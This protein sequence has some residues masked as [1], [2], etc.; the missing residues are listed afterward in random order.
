[1]N[2]WEGC[3][4]DPSRIEL[5]VKCGNE[6]SLRELFEQFYGKTFASVMALLRNHQRAEDITQEAFI[7]AFKRLNSLREPAKFG[8]WLASIATN[9]ARDS[10]KREKKYVLS[11]EPYE[12]G[13]RHADSN[14]E[15]QVLR[16]EES[17]RVRS[18][19]RTLPSEQYQVIILFYYYDQ[20]IEDIAL[21]LDISAG[22]VKSRLHRA[23]Q[24]LSALLQEREQNGA[25]NSL[26]NKEK[27]LKEG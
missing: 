18:V 14:V 13:N 9:L 12:T 3:Q 5:L 1:M 17:R 7:R 24:K 19:L 10:L 20:K 25:E 2:P 26:L 21:F 8:P 16:Y 4:L 27:D 11:E 23:K 15:E 6:D 22:T